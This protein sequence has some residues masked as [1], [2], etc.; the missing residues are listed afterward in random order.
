[1]TMINDIVGKRFGRL[2]VVR[3]SGERYRR[4]VIWILR[5]DCGNTVTRSSGIWIRGRTQSSCGI[6]GC[7]FRREVQRK[8]HTQH[9]HSR[10]DQSPTY[11][12]WGAAKGRCYNKNNDHYDNYGGRGISMCER[13]HTFTNFLEDMG[14]KPMKGWHIDRIN[15]DGNYE[16]GNCQWLSPEDNRKKRDADRQRMEGER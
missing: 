5:C 14:E 11:T 10:P 2:T 12:S 15:P 9:G 16:P 3:D 13:W 8:H 4:R 1:M 7:P 6:L